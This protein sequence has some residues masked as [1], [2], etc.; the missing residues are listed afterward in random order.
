MSAA[1]LEPSA[2]PM[3][4]SASLSASLPL[5]FS[6]SGSRSIQSHSA[7]RSG[8]VKEG[9][10]SDSG[11]NIRGNN[12][13]QRSPTSS[14]STSS[15]NLA[16]RQHLSELP[17]WP[18]GGDIAN[19]L[20]SSYLGPLY[21]V[22][23]FHRASRARPATPEPLTCHNAPPR[24]QSFPLGIRTELLGLF[25]SGHCP[26][27]LSD[28]IF[29]F[30]LWYD[31]SIASVLGTASKSLL[32]LVF[33][34]FQATVLP[35]IEQVL[36]GYDSLFSL[37]DR[38]MAMGFSPAPDLITRKHAYKAKAVSVVMAMLYVIV[39]TLHFKTSTRD[40][41]SELEIL[42]RLTIRAAK[43]AKL[44]DEALFHTV[45]ELHGLAA[46]PL[47][48]GGRRAWWYLTLIDRQVSLL[49]NREM[50]ISMEECLPVKLHVSEG[51]Y[52]ERKRLASLPPATTA[53]VSAPSGNPPGPPGT[54]PP[55]A[56]SLETRDLTHLYPY[57]AA[58]TAMVATLI[59][60][61]DSSHGHQEPTVSSTEI[62]TLPRIGPPRRTSVSVD[63][64]NKAGIHP[65]LDL[66]IPRARFDPVRHHVALMGLF[67]RIVEHRKFNPKPFLPTQTWLQIR[68]E[69]EMWFQE[70]P[71]GIKDL[72]KAVLRKPEIGMP[73]TNR[74][75][76][77][78]MHIL[79][80]VIYLLLMYDAAQVLLSSPADEYV[81]NASVDLDWLDTQAFLNA[82]E[83]AIRSTALL[84]NVISSKEAWAQISAP[85]FQFC[86]VRTGLVHLA[87]VRMASAALALSEPGQAAAQAHQQLLREAK[88]QM[89]VHTA[90]LRLGQLVAIKS[91]EM[92]QGQW[93]YFYRVWCAA[94]GEE[95]EFTSVFVM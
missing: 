5:S 42:L 6:A 73:A 35:A 82:Q 69:L 31:P 47:V 21:L 10:A 25:S 33:R 15:A 62:I 61:R 87:Y 3:A 45:T 79:H 24:F 11:S 46:P 89:D 81:Y 60:N 34:R 32:G 72:D 50:L 54:S 8:S 91:N 55:Q 63:G 52:E 29:F 36:V 58:G 19:L 48:E 30:A 84:Q 90:T 20:V 80:R 64:A 53:T 71:P 39:V 7:S 14:S 38:L 78:A 2:T 1:R 70:L 85:F 86:V 27:H 49:Y 17:A 28:A 59:Q 26:P 23:L 16:I 18:A 94:I 44:N 76:A 75:D 9:G 74:S 83:H 67:E 66:T 65:Q 22:S 95:L 93:S 68:S 12:K 13:E 51:E 88:Q 40:P 43:A 56:L 57:S 41:F 37:E 4:G 92:D 77:G